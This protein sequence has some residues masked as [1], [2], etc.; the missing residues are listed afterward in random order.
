MIHSKF[1]LRQLTSA[2]QQSFIF[3]LC[4]ALSM[5]TLVALSGFGDSIKNSLLRDARE[6]QA[7]DIIIDSSYA[8]SQPLAEQVT[9][10]EQQG[11]VESAQL[12]EF[13]SVVRAAEKED[14]VLANLKV[15]EPGYPFYGDVTLL[16][17]RSFDEVLS[18]GN[19][20]VAQALLETLALEVGDPLAVGEETL[21]IQDVL[22][23]EP[24]QP[25]SFFNLGPRIFV[26]ADDLEAINLVKPGSRVSY[27]TLLKV[28]DEG[29][30]ER[31]ASDL[32]AKATDRLERVETYKTA[33]SQVS[34]FFDNFILFLSL[35]AI[36]T[37]ILAGVGIQSS[38]TS[39]LK[40]R[41]KTIAIVKTVGATSRFVT[42]HYI[43]AA[44]F[45]GILGTAMGLALG[46]LMQGFLPV[47]FQNFL[48]P[49]VDLTLSA[50]AIAQSVLLGIFVVGVFTFLPIY[51]LQELKPNFIFQKE[52]MPVQ[53]G[54]PYYIAIVLIFLFFIGMVLWQ[55]QDLRVGMYFVGGVVALVLLTT[56]LTEIVLFFLKRVQIKALAPRQALR[57]LF[58]PRNS[59]K[60]IIITLATSLAVV[61]SIY[62]LQQNLE[63]NFTQSY[64]DDA[65]NV[66]FLDIQPDQREGFSELLGFE[67]EYFPV[68]RG[69][70]ME[71]N[72]EP[73]DREAEREREGDNLARTFNLTYRDDL[74]DTEAVVVGNKLFDSENDA[75]QVSVLDEM[76]EGRLFGVGDKMTFDIQGIEI[77]ATIN[78]VRQNT[79]ESIQPFFVFVF[80]E[81]VLGKAPQTIFTTARVEKDEVLS[82]Q[83]RIVAAFPNI[84][85]INV[86]EA[87][88][89][90]ASL[91][92][93]L[94]QI[95]TFFALF[96]I[97]AGV[98]IIISSVLATRFARIQ[99]A[100][101]FKVVGA[102]QSFVLRVFALENLFLGLVSALLALMLA[103]VASWAITTQ[104]FD[105]EYNAYFS[106]SLL[107]IVVTILLVMTVG[108][109]ASVSIL[110]QKPITFLREQTAE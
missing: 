8:L 84:T 67:T 34:T 45:L 96:S 74:L 78:S 55:L 18:A 5:M 6:L 93:Q 90:I 35:V 48:P 98:L 58:R 4:V 69:R 13:L 70:V 43:M 60:A 85:V 100:V 89:T 50:K 88:E 51:Q 44:A 22:L 107:L 27:T 109:L 80:P 57:G 14:T 64:P 16:S 2:K 3:V 41:E 79:S 62:L 101:Y 47:V 87:I 10:F 28:F 23:N 59:T 83:N 76:M 39:F 61:F 7:A 92:R 37:L 26:S 91:V 106:S 49:N 68:V 24:D 77:E 54:A 12:Y 99:E 11:L 30:L 1:I 52:A 36:F 38:L 56:L 19:V 73:L 95:I 97:I 46:F 110:R 75:P 103:Q 105:L 104:L 53:K 25:V 81:K 108:L 65:P 66:F 102:K 86:G 20:I 42:L 33:P 15:V 31:L 82:L 40:E 72:G 21:I 94:T 63:A 71:I 29:N 17:E 32:E 9:Q